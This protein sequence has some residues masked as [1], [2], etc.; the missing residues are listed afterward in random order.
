MSVTGGFTMTI[1]NAIVNSFT[2]KNYSAPNAQISAILMSGITV[3]DSTGYTITIM[4]LANNQVIPITIISNIGSTV[5]SIITQFVTEINNNL[6]YP[7]SATGTATTIILTEKS[8]T[9]GG[10]SVS[11][12]SGTVTQVA[13]LLT[14]GTISGGPYTAG[15]EVIQATSLATGYVLSGLAGPGLII[16]NTTGTFDPSHAVVGQ[17]SSASATPS[18]VASETNS[19]GGGTPQEVATLTN[20][21]SITTGQFRRYIFNYNGYSANSMISGERISQ[22]LGV[23]FVDETATN[24]AAFDTA[25]KSIPAGT[26]SPSTAYLGVL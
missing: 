14:L 3:A 15:E 9:T 16:S 8:Y 12:P 18:A 6:S 1:D 21:P 20:N 10:F 25:I 26:W 13:T 7:L 5:A 24:F 11:A 19:L 4:T 23:L 2:V 22:V 17:T